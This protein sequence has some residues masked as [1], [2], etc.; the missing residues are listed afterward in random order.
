MRLR[1]F[2]LLVL[3]AITG[4]GVLRAQRPFKDYPGVEYETF[5][6]PPDWQQT[7]G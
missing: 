1:S 5:P 4:W 7:T 2:L 6:L 3:C